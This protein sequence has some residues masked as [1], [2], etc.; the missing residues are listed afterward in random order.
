MGSSEM[1]SSAEAN[2]PTAAW[3]HHTIVIVAVIILSVAWLPISETAPQPI[4]SLGS[5]VKNFTVQGWGFFTKS[6]REA[7][8][9]PYSHKDGRWISAGRGPNAIPKYAFGLDRTSR[10]TEFDVQLASENLPDEAWTECAGLDIESCAGDASQV[11]VTVSGY[12]LRLC[13]DVV[14][15]STTPQPWAYRGQYEVT[16]DKIALLDISCEELGS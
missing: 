4:R 9:T 11:D 16:P 8:V 10:L 6:P 14:L 12:D 2:Q 1:S 15:A 5:Q 13:G 3:I 7:V